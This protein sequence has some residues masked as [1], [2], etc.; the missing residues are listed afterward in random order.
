MP[1]EKYGVYNT[2]VLRKQWNISNQLVLKYFKSNDPT[3]MAAKEAPDIKNRLLDSVGEGEGG[4][5]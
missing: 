1:L 5:I 3:C 2:T 4:V